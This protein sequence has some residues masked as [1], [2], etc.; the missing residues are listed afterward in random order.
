VGVHKLDLGERI[1][2]HL[3]PDHLFVFDARG[4]LVRAPL[5]R[6]GVR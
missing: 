4:P 5:V 3:N 2:L 6:Q 1:T